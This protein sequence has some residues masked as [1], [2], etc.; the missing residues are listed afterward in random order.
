[1][2]A[3]SV[4][5]VLDAFEAVG[6][7]AWLDGGWGVDALLGYESRGHEDLDLVVDVESLPAA[8]AKL[9]GMGFVMAVD[10]R[11]VRFEMEHPELGKIDFH[12]V[13]FD[14]GGGGLQRQHGDDDFR[15]PPEGFEGRG[16]VAGRE[17][18]CLTA[19]VQML[20][21]AGYVPD[22]T[23]ER[24]VLLLHQRFGI[25]LP[26]GYEHLGETLPGG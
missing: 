23:D 19:E 22:E 17:V 13:R 5:A 4:L 8:L 11:P 15:Y 14:E 7:R 20:V 6:V 24:D 16:L 25:E 18:A 2:N 9:Q 26:E 3:Q 12:P 21:H 10:E 1:L